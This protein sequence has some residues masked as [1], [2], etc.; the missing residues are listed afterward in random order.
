MDVIGSAVIL[1]LLAP[2][3]LTIGLYVKCVS[4]G[5]VLFRQQR[6]GIGGRPFDVW[7]FRTIEVSDASAQHRSHVADLIASDRP[8]EKCDDRLEVIPGGSL[9]R[10]LGIDELPQLINVLKGEMSLVG[11]RPDVVPV[12]DY[13]HWQRRRF[14][15]LPGITGLWQVSGKNRTTFTTMMRL[16]AAYVRRRSFW[17][18]L[19]ILFRTIPAILLE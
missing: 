10:R 2:F 15:V 3:L 1:V 19:W 12:D 11:P 9:L 17:L 5:T 18:D 8:L 14:E 16:D 13:I 6:F 7:K 4:R